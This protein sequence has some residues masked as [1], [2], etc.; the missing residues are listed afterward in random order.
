ME[1]AYHPGREP[2]GTCV[3]CGRLICPECE[4]IINN[5]KY[6]KQC[7]SQSEAVPKFTSFK[8]SVIAQPD[9]T[10]FT[11]PVQNRTSE[12]VYDYRFLGEINELEN[13]AKSGASW[14]FWIAVLSVINSVVLIAGGEWSFLVGLGITDVIGVFSKGDWSFLFLSFLIAG[15]FA[16]LGYFAYSGFTWA[17]IIGAVI[18]ILDGLLLAY[19]QMWLGMGFHV[20]ALIFIGRGLIANIKINT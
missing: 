10:A 7:L 15:I 4:V 5:K 2:I 18:Y 17:F 13:R 8:D 11:N 20:F 1:C 16:L 6:C 12:P 19:F 3:N 9:N 14:F